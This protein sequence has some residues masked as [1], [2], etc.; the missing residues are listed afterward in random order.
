MEKNKILEVLNEIDGFVLSNLND[1]NRFQDVDN[2]QVR[3]RLG[4]LQTIN[5][6]F[7]KT[8]E[9]GLL[10]NRANTLYKAYMLAMGTPARNTNM[11]AEKAYF[12]YVRDTKKIEG[13]GV[14]ENTDSALLMMVNAINTRNVPKQQLLDYMES[15]TNAGTLNPSQIKMYTSLK[16]MINKITQMEEQA[17]ATSEQETALVVK[18]ERIS[19][20]QK[21][22]DWLNRFTSK[23]SKNT[24]VPM[25]Q[26][27]I[28]STEKQFQKSIRQE[29]FEPIIPVEISTSKKEYVTNEQGQ[30]SETQQPGTSVSTTENYI[31][32]K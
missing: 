5:D 23:K 19:V 1:R 9:S 30:T 22:K 13:T 3:M 16:D 8:G 17:K 7:E 20:F 26:R 28:E 21:I 14:I 4:Q 12:D 27:A 18:K 29:G 6:E 31:G 10:A 2:I 11:A 15:Q 32:A 24:D 25:I